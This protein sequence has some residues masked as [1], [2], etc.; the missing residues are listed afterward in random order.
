MKHF[1]LIP[2]ETDLQTGYVPL[3]LMFWRSGPVYLLA[4]WSELKVNEVSSQV[5]PHFL[6]SKRDI[7][8]NKHSVQI[9]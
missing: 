4:E 3:Q 6:T 8:I 9:Y 1:F 7:I 5:T 2:G